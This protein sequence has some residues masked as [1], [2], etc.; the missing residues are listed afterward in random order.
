MCACSVASVQLCDPMDCGHQAPLSMGF[1]RQEHWSGLLGPPPGD[2]SHP[3][4]EPAS[5]VSSASQADTISLFNQVYT[6]FR[7]VF[8]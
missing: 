8:L 2:L 4:I 6:N 1:F 5:P 7:R 3:G